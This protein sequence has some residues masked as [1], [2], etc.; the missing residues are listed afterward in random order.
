MGAARKR[1]VVEILLAGT[2]VGAIGG[3]AAAQ[4]GPVLLPGIDVTASRLATI[5]IVG[6]STTVIT[7]EEIERSP[8]LTLQDLLSREPGIQTTSV[9]G[10]VNGAGTTVDMR[11]FGAAAASNTLVLINGRR[12]TDIDLNG[13]DFSA[14]PRNSIERIEITR[15]NSGGVLY[16]DGAV[17]GVINIITKSGAG[18]PRAA[19]LEGGYGSFNQREARASASASA[20][21]FSTS[22]FGEAI[23]SNGYRE[24]NSLRQRNAVGDL[25]YNA[26]NWSAY[27]NIWADDQKLG[28][29]GARLVTPTSSELETNR[30]GASTPTA[31]A[32]KQ[33]VNVTA[34]VTRMIGDGVELIVDGGVRRKEQQAFSEI[35]G[36][37]SSD[38]R[39]LVTASFT[40]RFIARRDLFGLPTKV[41]A[42]FDFYQS[43]FESNRSRFLRETP[44]HRY[45]L[46]Q[47]SMALYWHQ[48]V[49]IAPSTDLSWGARGQQTGLRARDRLDMTAPGA[50]RWESQA[51]ALDSSDSQHALHFGAEHRFTDSF[52]VF[53]RIARSFRMPNVDER[54][55]VS[56]FPVD[57]KLRPQTSRDIEAGVRMRFG[58]LD[59]QSSVYDMMLQDELHFIPFPPLGANTNLDPTWRQG[60][61]TIANWRV[62]ERLSFKGGL[63]FTRAVFRDGVNAGK[64]VP[65]VSRWTASA[66]MSWDVWQKYVVLDTS[67]RYVGERRMDNDQANFQPLIPAQTLVDMRV[68]GEVQN[69]FWS[70]AVQNLFDVQYF[71]Y[72][73]ASSS[74]FG[75]YNAYPQP[76]R[77]YLARLG[78]MFQ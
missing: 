62:N 54:V 75:R 37:P 65:L 16:G 20:G 18:R 61:E 66:G 12:Q 5:G 74:T 40:P 25:R 53:G 34:G 63:A 41:I 38:A 11:G 6:A 2:M 47:R 36:S 45:D 21:G 77:S 8:Q 30:R 56:A 67:V 24:N 78:L 7:S 68:G 28:L 48:T 31:F 17:G 32:D 26:E 46:T 59:I 64:D 22:V 55:G 14:I 69:L 43:D 70:F 39:E 10:G 3:V 76:G 58:T 73:V 35:G 33:G 4:Q 52:A 44:I 1:F 51:T 60:S 29:P 13:V 57:F 9:Y 49:A 15:G 27:V 42:G 71:D 72:A 19:R 23:N 50:T